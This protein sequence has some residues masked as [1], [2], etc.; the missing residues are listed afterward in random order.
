MIW[1]HDMAVNEWF[2]WN[3]QLVSV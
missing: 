3:V 2:N 1:K